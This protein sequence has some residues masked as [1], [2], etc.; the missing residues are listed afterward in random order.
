MYVNKPLY[1]CFLFLIDIRRTYPEN[2]Y[3]RD[4]QNSLLIS[5]KNVL[6]AFAHHNKSVGYCQVCE[7]FFIIQVKLIATKQ[8]MWI[9]D[10]SPH[11]TQTFYSDFIYS[12][13]VLLAFYD[14]AT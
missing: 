10:T 4:V 13:V 1:S 12:L 6:V 11:L 9:V 8:L 5:L 7:C 14:Y 2:I 3:F